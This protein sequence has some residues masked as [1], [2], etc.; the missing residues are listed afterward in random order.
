VGE[1]SEESYSTSEHE[2]QDNDQQQ[3]ESSAGKVSPV[4]T[5][6][7]SWQGTKQQQYQDD[8]KNGSKHDSSGKKICTEFEDGLIFKFNA[9]KHLVSTLRANR[10]S[11]ILCT[12][13]SPPEYSG[14]LAKK[15]RDPVVSNAMVVQRPRWMS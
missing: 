3:S 7:E 2:N 12:G 4:S 9:Y 10:L 13:F 5:V 15:V 11:C 1:R 14:A 6:R 8:E